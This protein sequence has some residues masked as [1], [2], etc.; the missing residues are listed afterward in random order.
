MLPTQPSQTPSALDAIVFAFEAAWTRDGAAD[1]ERFLPPPD[2]PLYSAALRELVC[3]DLEL[4]WRAGR[5]RSLDEYLHRFPAL[6]KDPAALRCAAWEEYRQRVQVGQTPD[7]AEYEQRYGVPTAD[8]SLPPTRP[9]PGADGFALSAGAILPPD[10]PDRRPPVSLVPMVG[11]AHNGDAQGLLRRRL[12]L[13]SLGAVGTLAYFAVLVLVTPRQKVGLF[14]GAESLVALNWLLLAVCG[15]LAVALWS[16][17]PLS[18]DRLRLIETVLVG[19]LAVEMGLG[20][21]TDLFFDDELREPLAAGDHALF[22]YSSS[23]SL[24]FFALIV[25]YGTLIP[26]SARR[27]ALVV[28][29]L[30]LVPL[31]ISTAAGAVAGALTAPFLRSFLLQMALW[32]LAAAAIAAYGAHRLEVLRREASEAQRVGQYRLVRRLGA[33]GMGEVYLAEHVLLRRPCAVKVIRAELAGDPGMRRRFEQE[34]RAAAALTHPNTCTVFDYGTADDGTFYC[35]MEYLPGPTLAQLVARDGPLA[36]GR[37]V[38][39][40]RQVCGALAEAHS[41][42]LVHRDVKPGNVIVCARGGVPDVAKLLDFGLVQGYASGESAERVFA[43]TPA[44]A[45]PEQA[46][47]RPLDARSDVYSLGAVAYFLLTGKPPFD[48]CGDQETMTA[49]VREPVVPPRTVCP[50]VPAGLEAVVLR[51]L[52]KDPGRRF[53][54]A[55]ELNRALVACGS[56]DG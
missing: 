23:W 39:L 6:A 9:G 30:A 48:R 41:V 24:P 49:H 50:E 26:A 25:G 31:V 44:Y 4:G 27:C 56:P 53:P 15:A 14:L 1:P 8:W 35:A 45:S 11:H 54:D 2:D 36:P 55:A 18:L 22:H 29:A 40:L 28:T 17:R 38:W 13:V 32:M 3:V 21:F 43:G 7:P 37:A 5:P 33:G 42:G 16:R 52:E 51:C 46:E 34:A 20:L 47:G 19:L 10:G 12:R